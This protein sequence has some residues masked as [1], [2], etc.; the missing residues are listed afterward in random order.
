MTTSG[1]LNSAKSWQT[2]PLG[3]K[4]L[5]VLPMK[6]MASNSRL[7]SATA[8]YIATSP[9]LMDKL[10]TAFSMVQPV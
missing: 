7:P 6:A 1:T 2:A 8:L 10:R 9:A 5:S 3:T 4:G